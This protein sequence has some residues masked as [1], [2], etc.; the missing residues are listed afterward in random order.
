MK[1]TSKNAQYLLT[2]QDIIKELN[3]H[4]LSRVSLAGSTPWSSLTT[5]STGTPPWGPAQANRRPSAG[6]REWEGS[7][8]NLG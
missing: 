7:I 8:R 6:R 3:Y 4:R 5:T 2:V 1:E